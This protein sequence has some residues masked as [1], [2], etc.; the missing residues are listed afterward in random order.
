MYKC[1]C[2]GKGSG[3]WKATVGPTTS[4]DGETCDACGYYVFWD[5]PNK[6]KNTKELGVFEPLHNSALGDFLDYGED[7]DFYI[8]NDP[9]HMA[10]RMQYANEKRK[11]QAKQRRESRKVH[12]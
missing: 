8:H 10:S 5:S 9:E 1:N 6:T 4:K 12:K 2:H 3:H 7:Y 11:E